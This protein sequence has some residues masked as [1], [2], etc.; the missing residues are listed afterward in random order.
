M[1]LYK[2]IH[3]KDECNDYIGISLLSMPGKMYGRVLTEGLME[4]TR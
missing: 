1:L 3:S 2:G 4:I